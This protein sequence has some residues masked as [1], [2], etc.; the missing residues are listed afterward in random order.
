MS[1]MDIMH[2][3][4]PY[5]FLNTKCEECKNIPTEHY[6]KRNYITNN[7]LSNSK[8]ISNR[9]GR[10]SKLIEPESK[11]SLCPNTNPDQE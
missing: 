9:V 10:S 4:D 7:L 3:G 1:L 2:I 8:L 6:I 5:I 11:C